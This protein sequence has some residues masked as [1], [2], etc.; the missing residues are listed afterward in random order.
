[1][2]TGDNNKQNQTP[3]PGGEN[4]GTPTQ[5]GAT[6]TGDTSGG[7]RGDMPQAATEKE[8]FDPV[9]SSSQTDSKPESVGTSAASGVLEE[10]PTQGAVAGDSTP[11][12]QEMS[13][14]GSNTTDSPVAEQPSSSKKGLFIAL[15][16]VIILVLLAVAGYTALMM[17]TSLSTR[18]SSNQTNI[19]PPTAAPTQSASTS[20]SGSLDQQAQGV[21]VGSVN[22]DLQNLQNDVNQL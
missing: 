10:K 18:P 8:A 14:A 11:P 22:Q 15:I 21:D 6:N 12:S 4:M 1:M 3:V 7:V 16:T 17:K 13:P 2:D 20:A 9:P 19:T 5:S